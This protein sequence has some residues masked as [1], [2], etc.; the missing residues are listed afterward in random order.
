MLKKIQTTNRNYTLIKN[1]EDLSEYLRFE[2]KDSFHEPASYPALAYEH[3]WDGVELTKFDYP[4][5]V[6]DMAAA[7]AEVS[8]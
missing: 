7:F 2:V 5:D 6:E 4:D 1:R 8:K 3:P